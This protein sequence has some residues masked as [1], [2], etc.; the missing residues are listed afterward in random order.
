MPEVKRTSVQWDTKQKELALKICE[1]YTGIG[2]SNR[3]FAMEH[4]HRVE[5]LLRGP[6]AA[7]ATGVCMG[8]RKVGGCKG[9]GVWFVNGICSPR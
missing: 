4:V 9:V 3:P 5:I 7:S 1:F 8:G 2:L 6:S